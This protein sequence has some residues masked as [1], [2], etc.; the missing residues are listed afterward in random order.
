MVACRHDVLFW[1]N[2]F[3]YVEEPRTIRVDGLVLPTT[4]PFITWPHQDGPIRQMREN[5]GLRDIGVEKSRA[6]GL[7]WIACLLALHDWI[8]TPG[9]L[10]GF[11]SKTETDT[12]SPENP[13]SLFAKLDWELK[14]LPSW[15]IG[16]EKEDWKRN[17]AQHSLTHFKNR[18]RIVGYA[19][20]PNMARGHRVRWFLLDELAAWNA[21]DDEQAMTS[22]QYV[23]PSRLLIS[24]PEGTD[25]AYY[26]AMHEPSN[27][28]RIV[29]DWKDNPWQNRGL[30]RHVQGKMVALDPVNNPLPPNY[31]AESREL[32]TRL[33]QKG[34]KLSGETRSPWYD[35]QCDRTNAN[36]KSIAQ[37]LDRDYGGSMYRIFGGD[38]VAKASLDVQIPKVRGTLTYHAETL[39]PEFDRSSDGPFHLWLNLDSK[40]R[41][42]EQHYVVGCDIAS[43]LGGPYSSNSVLCV[44]DGVTLEQVLEY[45]TNTTPEEEF[46]DLAIATAK[47]FHDAYLIWERS[48]QS[49]QGFTKRVLDQ[50]YPNIYRRVIFHRRTRKRTQEAGWVTGHTTKEIMLGE[51]R[52]SVLAGELKIRSRTALQETGYYARVRGKIV[53]T[54]SHQAQDD[55]SVGVT[56]GDRVI[57]MAVAL[58]GARDRP[59][60][61][62]G[63]PSAVQEIPTNSIAGRNREWD[64]VRKESSKDWDGR[65]TWD[66][67][68]PF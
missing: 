43:G 13:G 18:S 20:T 32:M 41:P 48:G 67:V 63:E 53:Q 42:P 61:K 54:L 29:V 64:E 3:C 60:P 19:N 30:Y 51:L 55:A 31:E 23:T 56:H 14:R 37:E 12:D 1:M 26:R 21:G 27:M 24:T 49:G 62:D 5:L 9:S 44:L 22:T 16:V 40:V 15:M 38:F 36:P 50:H 58:Q 25:G 47:W 35:E 39:K 57:A 7:T 4:L 34:F 17:L 66:L 68:E 46:A 10:V 65:T 2:C 59:W 33:R 11:V 45:A 28:L 52:R 8:F 6:Q